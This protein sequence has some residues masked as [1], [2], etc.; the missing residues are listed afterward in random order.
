MLLTPMSA[1][2]TL[3]SRSAHARANCDS[4]WP[5]RSAIAARARTLAIFSSL[6]ISGLNEPSALAREPSGTPPR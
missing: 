6:S 2:V 4:F 1:E 5:R 3:G